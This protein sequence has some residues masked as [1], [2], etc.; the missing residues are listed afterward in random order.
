[1]HPVGTKAANK[2]GIYDMSGNAAE[3]CYDYYADWG[4]GELTNPVHESGSYRCYRGGSLYDYVNYCTIFY[5]NWPYGSDYGSSSIG[6]RI[7]Q[8]YTE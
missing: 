5:R 1:M 4:T 8:N 2:L 6:L 3:W 7:A